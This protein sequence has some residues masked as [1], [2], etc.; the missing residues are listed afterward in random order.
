M[1]STFKLFA[2]KMG[3]TAATNYIGNRGEI[4]YDPTSTTLRISDGVNAGGNEYAMGT[5]GGTSNRL[6]NGASELV[7]APEGDITLPQNGGIVFDRANTSIRVGMG[8]HIASGE[9][10]DIQAIDETDPANLIY[11]NWYFGTDGKLTLPAGG[12][13]FESDGLTGTA[14]KLTP[15]GGANVYQALLIYPTTVEGDHIHL[16]AGGGNT[17]LYLGDDFQYV[18]L[19][20]NGDIIVKTQS[21]AGP[22]AQWTFGTDG[23]L[24]FPDASTQAGGALPLTQ[25]KTI[26]A[27]AASWTD[28]QAAIAA[29]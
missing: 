3:G 5:G 28:F 29:L 9:G 2:D 11:K 17:E 14:I 6:V 7:L 21:D 25:L 19:A 13:I 18:K 24:T 26:V 16:A 1:A 22:N 12:T 4:F 8:F 10:I 20:N 23:G 15:A 27:A